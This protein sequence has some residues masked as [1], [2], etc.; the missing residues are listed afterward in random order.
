[1]HFKD[2]GRG[3][4]TRKCRWPGGVGREEDMDALLEPLEEN[5]AL[6]NILIFD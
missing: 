5:A 2:G 1:M 3:P 6:T 4:W